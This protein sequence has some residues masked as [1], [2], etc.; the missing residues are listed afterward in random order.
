MPSGTFNRFERSKPIPIFPK[1]ERQTKAAETAKMVVAASDTLSEEANVP[2]HQ[3]RSVHVPRSGNDHASP[4]G[5]SESSQDQR[6]DLH[7]SVRRQ[8]LSGDYTGGECSH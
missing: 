1:V 7:G 4:A 8:R 2:N 3:L 5:S 6:L